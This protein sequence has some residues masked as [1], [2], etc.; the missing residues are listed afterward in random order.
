VAITILSTLA[1]NN[2]V[3]VD[4]EV[5]SQVVCLIVAKEGSFGIEVNLFLCY[6]LSSHDKFGVL[7]ERLTQPHFPAG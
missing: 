2:G 4:D 7:E 5:V 6:Y 1:S 3:H